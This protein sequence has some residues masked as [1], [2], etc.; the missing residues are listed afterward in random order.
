LNGA[1]FSTYDICKALG[2]RDQRRVP[3]YD[4]FIN[5]TIPIKKLN[6]RKKGR[7]AKIKV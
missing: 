3:E 5:A 7:F 6:N 1:G 4:E 2:P